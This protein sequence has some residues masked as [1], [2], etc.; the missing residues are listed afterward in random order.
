MTAYKSFHEIGRGEA[1]QKGDMCVCVC[2]FNHDWSTLMCG[3]DHQN[4][5][6]QLSSN[7]KKVEIF[8][9]KKSLSHVL[10][11]GA[12]FP[13]GGSWTYIFP[14]PLQSPRPSYLTRKTHASLFPM[15][16]RGLEHSPVPTALTTSRHGQCLRHALQSSLD[17]S[18]FTHCPDHVFAPSTVV[19][20]SSASLL[21]SWVSRQESH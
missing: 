11:E 20:L 5:V 2:V 1:Q 10:P 9:K 8:K 21:S 12:C 17:L 19:T 13:Q 3:R 16:L 15:P 14:F 18:H 6:K 7:S 4:I